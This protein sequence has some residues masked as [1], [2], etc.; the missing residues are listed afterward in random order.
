MNTTMPIRFK[1]H[2]M[3]AKRDIFTNKALADMTGI[4]PWRIGEIIKGRI[5][6]IDTETL[7]KLCRELACQPGDLLEYVPED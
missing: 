1:V 2:E 3:M 7:E 5:K 6:R 4:A